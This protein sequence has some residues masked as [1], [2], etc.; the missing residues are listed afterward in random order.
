M[1]KYL[2]M[3]YVPM[4]V[5]FIGAVFTGAYFFSS[6]SSSGNTFS[7]GTW[8]IPDPAMVVINEV[9]ADPSGSDNALM[10]GGEWIELYNSGGTAIDI[11]GWHLYD[12][13]NNNELPISNLNVSGGST[14]LS[15][16][17]Y[18]VVFRNGDGDF[19]LN[20]TTGDSVRLYNGTISG[21]ATIIDSFSYDIGSIFTDKTW[22]RIPNGSAAWLPNQVSSIGG[23]NI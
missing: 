14:T 3:L 8:V 19:V 23:P 15:A 9:M 10:L 13:D 5:I 4:S 11:N 6:V 22:A 2:K 17:G 1:I 16:A 20:N 7:A 21:G 12:S 18:L